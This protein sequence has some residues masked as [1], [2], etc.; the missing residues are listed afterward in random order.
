M[1]LP[2]ERYLLLS[3]RPTP[4]FRMHA[5]DAGRI[6]NF[7]STGL[8]FVVSLLLIVLP[9]GTQ[10]SRMMGVDGTETVMITKRYFTTLAGQEGIGA[11][12]ILI[13]PVAISA[14]PLA[15]HGTGR[16]RKWRIGCAVVLTALSLLAGFS[17]GLFYI[18][19][20]AAMWW[21]VTRTHE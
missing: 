21:A 17:V 15:T 6:P 19:A 2:G 1:L 16:H 9:I 11:L 4:K 10:E 14:A 18:P 12:S 3:S 20:A 5:A 7:I 8:A 13:A